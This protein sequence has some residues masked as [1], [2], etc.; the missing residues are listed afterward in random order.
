M[1][2]ENIADARGSTPA[3]RRHIG[4]GMLGYAFMGRA[5]SSAYRRMEEIP[6]RVPVPRLVA[7]AGR[8][9]QAVA[10]AAAR[11]GWERSTTDWR[12]LV[13]DPNI[14]L[15][16]NGGPNHLHAA[17][18]IA[19]VRNGK[20][21][22]CEKPLG[23]TAEESFAVWEA[24]ATA[25]V[26]HMC[27]FNYRFVPAVRLAREMI[28]S[29]ALGEIR[30]FRASYLQDWGIDAEPDNWRFDPE[31]AGTGALG[32]L[33]THVVD[34]AHYLVGD[35]AA[36]VAAGRTF[37]PNRRVDDAVV[38]AAEFTCG[39]LGTFEVSRVSLG[40]R[41]ALRWQIEGTRAS[42]AF[43]LERLGELHIYEADHAHVTGYT[44]VV[45]ADSGMP[46]A[47]WWWP[48]GHALGWEHTFVHEIHHLLHAI[49]SDAEIGPH[50][51]T[52]ED[53]YRAAVVCDAIQRSSDGG[54]REPV[55]YETVA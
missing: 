45:T 13:D 28:D 3:E 31:A 42:L 16:D 32:D 22:L 27:G 4:V 47:S 14:E 21:V 8:N 5:H 7:L 49:E 41:N 51:A 35:V 19:A 26:K 40:H 2:V 34:L 20:H 46:Y 37:I 30:H 55:V 1:S 50:G 6:S 12:E 48:P 11:F 9:A 43:D 17:P 36:V 29:G 33:G 52:F 23:R 38:A 25:G 54:G 24:A 39:T 10:E 15:F 53:G 18:T 44:R